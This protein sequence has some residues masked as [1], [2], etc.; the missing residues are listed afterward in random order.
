[1][2]IHRRATKRDANEKPIVDALEAVGAVVTR[3]S[4]D[5]VPDIMCLW[6]GAITLLEIKSPKGRLTPSQIDYHAT[7]LNVGV[8]VHV[9][10]TP[11]EGLIAIGAIEE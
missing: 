1:M 2:S 7:A 9:V 10:H 11:L 8:K 5:G 3:L 6:R 4:S